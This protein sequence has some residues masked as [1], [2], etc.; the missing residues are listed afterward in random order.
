M[1]AF[2]PTPI[3]WQATAEPLE[4]DRPVPLWSVHV[5]DDTHE[6]DY[7]IDARIEGEAVGKAVDQ[8][9]EEIENLE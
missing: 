4:P 9:I 7:V 8:F 6:R 1:R 3:N 2:R 5:W